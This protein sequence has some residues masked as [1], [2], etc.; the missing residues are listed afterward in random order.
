M[1][2]ICAYYIFFDKCRGLVCFGGPLNAGKHAGLQQIAIR[3]MLATLSVSTH[4]VAWSK[5]SLKALIQP[6][7]TT[8]LTC[9]HKYRLVFYGW[10]YRNPWL[11]TIYIYIYIYICIYI[12][13]IYI[14]IYVYNSTVQFTFK[15]LSIT[16]QKNNTYSDVL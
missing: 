3:M 4:M 16:R 9:W 8:S 1:K 13:Y 11:I 2:I 6:T 15:Y 14:Y 10:S 12:L 5:P 7:L